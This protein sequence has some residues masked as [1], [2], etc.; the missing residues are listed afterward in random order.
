[1]EELWEFNLG[2]EFR[3]EDARLQQKSENL[4][5]STLPNVPQQRVQGFSALANKLF[6]LLELSHLGII[7]AKDW[8]VEDIDTTSSVR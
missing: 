4:D 7:A 6:H 3:L 2:A 5:Y 1:M 8:T